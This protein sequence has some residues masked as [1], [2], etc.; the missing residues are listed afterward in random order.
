MKWNMLQFKKNKYNV[1]NKE[2]TYAR[3]YNLQQCD[4]Y[5][6]TVRKAEPGQSHTDQTAAD[7]A[8]VFTTTL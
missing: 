3:F 2:N 7:D 1:E 5:N 8:E 6:K 4:I